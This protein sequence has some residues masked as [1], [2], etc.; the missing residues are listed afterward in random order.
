MWLGRG[1]WA[2]GGFLVGAMSACGGASPLMH[3]PHAVPANEIEVGAG[4]SAVM[5]LGAATDATSDSEALK[6]GSVAPG[7][8]PWVS[9]RLGIDGRYDV[10]LA[11]T[12]RT[13]RLDAR[14]AFE[15]GTRTTA[16]SVGAGLSGVLPK[17]DDELALRIGGFGA[18]VPVVIGFR[19]PADIYAVWLGVRGGFE[20]LQGEREGGDV[21][22][23]PSAPV[24]V[25]PIEAWHGTAGGLAGLR[26]GFAHLFAVFEMGAAMHFVDGQVGGRS[27]GFQAFT[28]SPAAALMGRF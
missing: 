14:R 8:A 20:R 27:Q 19:S 10:G 3:P 12:G 18:D 16:L 1:N 9:G 17:R 28:L 4:F 25:E 23:D 13:V 22:L 6:H 5:D 7:L 26:V 2:L 15:F 24:L 21:S 11:Y